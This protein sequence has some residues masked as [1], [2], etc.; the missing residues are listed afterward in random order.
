MTTPNQSDP[1]SYQQISV[2]HYKAM[3]DVLA[4]AMSEADALVPPNIAATD[5]E[6]QTVR[7]KFASLSEF[8]RR[9]KQKAEKREKP[10]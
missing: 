4:R 3:L 2:A 5:L 9:Q 6:A 1:K 10:S 7:A 8:L